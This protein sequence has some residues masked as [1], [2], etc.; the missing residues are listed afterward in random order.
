MATTHLLQIVQSEAAT[1]VRCRDEGLLFRHA[2]GR[3]AQP[4]FHRDTTC[5]SRIVMVAEAPNLADTFDPDKGRITVDAETDPTGR[6]MRQ[7]L[8]SVGL[9]PE[10]V[11]VTN[12][13][14]CLPA[15]NGGKFAVK[16]PIA[17]NCRPWLERLIVAADARVVVTWGAVA[18]LGTRNVERHT[19]ELREAVGRLHPWFGRQ[20][21]P[22][23]HPGLLAR[24]NRST[25][26]QLE[27]ISCLR[28]VLL[29]TPRSGQRQ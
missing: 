2:D 26:Q 9:R 11:L 23:Y 17:R 25:A 22:L 10:D 3:W 21:L 20:L 15:K 27:D 13:A 28:T 19:L 24:K 4:L 18:L 29:E 1:C 8:E 6:F 12:T 5:P 7:L 16:A 14:L